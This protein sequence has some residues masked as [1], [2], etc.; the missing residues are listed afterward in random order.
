MVKIL[1]HISALQKGFLMTIGKILNVKNKVSFIARDKNIE[2]LLKQNFKNLSIKRIFVEEEVNNNIEEDYKKLKK[3]NII[4]DALLYEK[5]YN[6]DLSF[7]LG[8]DRAL[9]RGYLLNVDK[10]PDIKRANWSKEKKILYFLNILK[11]IE[12]IILSTRP[13]V[14]I[15]VSRSYFI[16]IISK[17]YKIKYLTLTAARIGNRFFWCDNDSNTS[18]SL[19]KK[20]QNFNSYKNFN[21]IFKKSYKFAQIVESKQLHAKIKYNLLNIFYEVF[22]Q[23]LKEFK[24]VIKG[25][26]RKFSYNILGWAPVKIRKY[27]A[28]KFVTKNS[29]SLKDFQTGK[30]IY[31]PLNLE[32]E[33]ALLG[34][35]PEFNNT[36]EMITWV[37]KSL[38]ADY[39]IVIKEQPFAYGTRS[40]WFYKIY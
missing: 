37:S 30:F 3:N 2:K 32:P 35:S 26:R 8:K 18:S 14:I 5:K 33:I 11:N 10:Y 17:K 36:L 12:K 7:F 27:F 22:L 40:K 29:K 13:K 28:Y 25:S 20:L 24:Q 23:I 1:I 31:I 4:K 34:I 39:S 38:P 9:G 6:I 15:S 16:S 19:I 21:K